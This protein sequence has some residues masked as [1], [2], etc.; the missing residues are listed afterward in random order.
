MSDTEKRIAKID[1][2]IAVAKKTKQKHK[3][4]AEI[5]R[6]FKGDPST[7]DALVK[8]TGLGIDASEAQRDALLG[9]LKA[10]HNSRK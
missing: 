9:K 10:K 4:R 7:Q 5:V 6:S 8:S 1:S 3:A 2:E